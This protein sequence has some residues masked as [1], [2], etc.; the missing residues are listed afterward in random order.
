MGWDGILA[1][2]KHEVA[3]SGWERQGCA[4]RVFHQS[5]GSDLPLLRKTLTQCILSPRWRQAIPKTRILDP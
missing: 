1:R 4:D 5:E 3:M 2:F